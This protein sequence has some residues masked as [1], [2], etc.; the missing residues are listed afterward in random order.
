M[1]VNASC[2]DSERNLKID[3]HDVP[4][5][6]ATNGYR[7]QDS[8]V[9][10]QVRE[11]E[12]IVS[13]SR[14]AQRSPV[15]RDMFQLPQPAALSKV[16]AVALYD[17][18]AA[19]ENEIDLHEGECIYNIS[20]PSDDWWEGVS[21]DGTQSG[22]FPSSYVKER[23]GCPAEDAMANPLDNVGEGPLEPP[24]VPATAAKPDKSTSHG[25]VTL[26][27]DPAEF[28]HYLWMIH[29][30]ILDFYEF[31]H[32]PA[33]V[34]KCTKHLS[35]ASIAHMY[36][37]TRIA[38]R[39]LGD[40]FTL[41]ESRGSPHIDADLA[42]LL[43]RTSSRWV[44][45]PEV[46]VRTRTI[47]KEAMRKKSA[48]T[49]AVILVAEP[50]DDRELL[51]WGY[52]YLLLAGKSAWDQDKRMRPIDR[53]RLLAGAYTLAGRWQTASQEFPKAAVVP[54]GVIPWAIFDNIDTIAK[55]S[56][57]SPGG[58]FGTS[59]SASVW[60]T[61]GDTLKREIERDLYKVFDPEMWSL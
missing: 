49:F 20:K 46:L 45:Q 1:P 41:L 10:L 57:S 59:H 4:L 7:Y 6:I 28:E 14:L 9:T 43:V 36:Q 60:S 2:P 54:A 25:V 19:E 29:A 33:S 24:T 18:E 58:A 34:A 3:K 27:N 39:S 53:R 21:A 13:K 16:A 22:L 61:K 50:L 52:Y 30:D 11:K 17:Y 44:D 32:Q 37:S 23:T 48:D 38:N 42:A 56:S 51:G 26:D 15:F 12:Y 35:I 5:W 47:L 31:T 40:A 8:T 55:S